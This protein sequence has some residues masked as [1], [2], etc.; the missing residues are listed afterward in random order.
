MRSAE[1][2]LAIIRTRGERRLPIDDLYRQLFNPEFFL[3]A[4][5]KVSRNAGALTA[6][7]NADTV[8]GMSLER[9]QGVI[10]A[11]RFERYRWTPVRRS[12]LPKDGTDVRAIGIPSWS[13]KL[14][15]EAMRMMLEAYSEPQF[16][17]RSHGFRPGRGC[18]TALSE[19]YHRWKGITWFLEGDIRGCFDRIDHTVLLSILREKILDRR[20][21]RLLENLLEAGYLEEWRYRSTPSGVPQGGIL[22]P[23]LANI[24]LDRFDAF[25]ESTL[26]PTNNR[27]D[28]RKQSV[29]YK[30]LSDRAR[31]LMRIGRT[32][33][34]RVLRQ[35]V[36]TLP[37]RVLIDPGFRRLKYIRY[38][39]DFLFGFVGPRHEAERIRRLVRAFLHDQLRLEPSEDKNRVVHA[40]T[41]AVRFLGYDVTVMQDDHRHTKGQRSI[42]GI[43]SLR[44]PKDVIKAKCQQYMRH[45]VPAHRPELVHQSAIDIV[46]QYQSVY[47]GLVNFYRMAHNLR[48]LGRVHGV[49]QRSLTKTLAWKF[50]ISVPQVYRRFRRRI[51]AED[52]TQR[53]VLEVRME[54]EG[55][56]PLTAR[57]GGI[58]LAW[59]V[60]TSLDDRFVPFRFINTTELV[61]RLLAETCELC[62]SRDRIQVH[63]IRA[64][65]ELKR[66]GRSG[67]PLWAKLMAARRRKTLVLCHRCHVD[68]HAGSLQRASGRFDTGEP[69]DAKV[70]S[71]VR[72]GADGKG[73]RTQDLAG[74]LPYVSI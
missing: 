48:N 8:D 30:K 11:L 24:Y 36:Q 71:P 19:I 5:S 26:L 40:R 32:D 38:A 29:D 56:A 59:K 65:R 50:R 10:E 57:W 41:E 7:A 73:L 4:Y 22:S 55:K 68:I 45:G 13:D 37:S 53:S 51:V 63:H 33:E 20:F 16:N 23:I 2:C 66:K 15:Q 43:V 49:M 60:D 62:G 47:R 72:W 70:S 44:V 9:I 74:G 64:L 46:V 21:L 39:D 14:L 69:D 58:S 61:Q 18:H 35:Q 28:A 12:Y 34:A 31:Y 1:T 42:N 27:G 52:G 17:D 6:G 25:V 3:Q 67:K 54:R